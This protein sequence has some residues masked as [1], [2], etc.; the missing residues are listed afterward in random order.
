MLAERRAARV[1]ADEDRKLERPP[2]VIAERD[3]LPAE[4]RRVA[5]RAGLEV[6]V[7][8]SADADPDDVLFLGVGQGFADHFFDRREYRRG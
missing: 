2:D 3:V 8:G 5:D 7:A 6:D 1:V 4:V